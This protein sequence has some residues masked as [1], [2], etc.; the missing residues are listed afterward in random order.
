MSATII[1]FPHR[2]KQPWHNPPCRSEARRPYVDD[3]LEAMRRAI[4]RDDRRPCDAGEPPDG[5]AA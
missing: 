5:T 4:T 1:P 2:P 3:Y